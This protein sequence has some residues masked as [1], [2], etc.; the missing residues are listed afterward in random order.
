MLMPKRKDACPVDYRMCSQT[1]TVYH[2]EDGKITRTEYPR[3]FLDFRKNQTVD[4]TGSREAN[5]FLLVIPCPREVNS[6]DPMWV[7]YLRH[8]NKLI[9]V[10]D[11]VMKGVG[12]KV[13]PE[14]W[15]AFIPAKVP[16][17]VVVKYV[18]PKYWGDRMVHVEAGG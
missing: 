15:A 17:L 3:A 7:A 1:V 12:P 16:G 4:K 10:G 2:Y 8:S 18:D 13:T 6:N 5:S 14:E 9:S 11:K